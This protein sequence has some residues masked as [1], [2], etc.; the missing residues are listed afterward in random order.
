M[1]TNGTAKSNGTSARPYDTAVLGLKNY[2]YPIFGSGEVGKKPRGIQVQGEQVVVMRGQK[3]GKVYAMDDECVHRGSLLSAGRGCEFKGTNTITCGYHGWTYNIE[4]GMC[5]AVLPEGR[6]SASSCR[7][8]FHRAARVP[9][10]AGHQGRSC[11]WPRAH[12][13]AW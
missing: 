4:D 7:S 12:R 9:R 6:S 5:V 2:W 10:P 11:R 8:R 1:A 13:T 3:D